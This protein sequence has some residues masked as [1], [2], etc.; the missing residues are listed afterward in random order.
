MAAQLS[1]ISTTPTQFSII[2]CEDA[3]SAICPI[4]QVI[5]GDVKEYWTQYPPLE[6]TVS[7]WP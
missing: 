2:I 3:D 7:D 4:V 5:N 6:F 1:G